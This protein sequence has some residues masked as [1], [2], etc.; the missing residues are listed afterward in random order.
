MQDIKR[1]ILSVLEK[2]KKA[3]F[4]PS[5][6]HKQLIAQGFNGTEGELEKTLSEL[7]KEG[8]IEPQTNAFGR[9][10]EPSW[11]RIMPEKATQQAGEEESIECNADFASSAAYQLHCVNTY[12]IHPF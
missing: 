1:A 5:F 9:R 7:E 4:S 2:E 12:P 11:Y 3:Y 6:I 10:V 8:T